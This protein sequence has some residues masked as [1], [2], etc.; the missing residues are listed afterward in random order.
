MHREHCMLT[1]DFT[2]FARHFGQYIQQVRLGHAVLAVRNGEP[3]CLLIH[4]SLLEEN[5]AAQCEQIATTEIYRH[6]HQVCQN[7]AA[8]QTRYLINMRGHPAAS[9]V[10]PEFLSRA[11]AVT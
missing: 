10:G 11:L 6:T 7:A 3:Y 9:L 4:P 2:H 8:G 1:I 5:E